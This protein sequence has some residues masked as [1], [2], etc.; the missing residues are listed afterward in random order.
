MLFVVVVVVFDDDVF[1]VVE[2]NTG[3]LGLFLGF[4]CLQVK[5]LFVVA[6]SVVFVYVFCC[7]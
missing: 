6:I 2:K 3:S 5:M 1:F 7:C 4:S